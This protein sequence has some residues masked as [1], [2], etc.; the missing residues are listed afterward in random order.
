MKKRFS[1]LFILFAMLLSMAACSSD[2]N[3]SNP[4]NDSG[5]AATVQGEAASDE[6]V[7]T[8]A[9]E[10]EE[11]LEL[12]DGLTYD[13]YEFRFLSRTG[14]KVNEIWAE[15][16]TGNVLN[17]AVYTRNIKIEE[18]FD[19]SLKIIESSSDD[20]ETDAI[21]VIQAG[22]DAYDV[23]LPHAR[24]SFVYA[25]RNLCFNWFDI[26]NIDLD[27]SW[28]SADA[29]E[30]FAINGK[31]YSMT[32]DISYATLGATTGMLFN[33]DLF[34]DFQ[35]EYPY[36]AAANG[37]WTFDM[38]DTIART[39]SIDVN[40]DGKYV[41][42]DDLFGYGTNHWLGPIEALYITGE[43][44]ITMT[45]GVPSLTVYSEKTV[46]VYDKFMSLLTSN[47][48]W[49][50]LGG[51]A[52]QR[53]FC[54]GLL[55]F[56]DC[57]ISHLSND[58]FRDA[59]INFGLIPWPKYDETIGR[60]YSF[61]GAGSTLWSIPITNPDTSR[62]GAILEAMAYYGQKE[63]IPAYYDVTLQ[64]KYLRDENSVEMLDYIMVGRTFDLGYFNN[65][66]FGGAL[67]NVGYD[68]VHDTTLSL[69]D[70]YERNKKSVE[71]LIENSYQT[72]LGDE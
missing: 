59:E 34:D 35:I 13:G 68:L 18:M 48:G 57:E 49:N 47:A 23:I 10:L 43:R 2:N 61:V 46:D 21:P 54:E 52:H 28:W 14:S 70:L 38:F 22:D 53:A 55:A 19:I 9:P 31:L 5:A 26:E 15:E 36:A 51:D 64:N 30:N 42:G 4:A 62:T 16:L 44:V 8:E 58:Y 45:D 12:P 40:G 24:A 71:N 50:Q 56:V 3:N 25:Q 41:Q 67:A 39:I 17:D 69:T 11:V 63:I 1:A 20:Y 72:Y 65:S 32:G 37:T 6:D 27:K 33:K 66:Q 29:R 60:Y 7:E